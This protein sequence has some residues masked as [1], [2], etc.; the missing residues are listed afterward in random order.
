M[1]S[2][3]VAIIIYSMYGHIAKR[4]WTPSP[5]KHVL[6]VLTVIL[7]AESVKK[8]IIAAGGSAQIY[9]YVYLLHSR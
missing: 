4:E 3:R 6:T 5:T 9:Q 7:V 8:G 1:P 2:P